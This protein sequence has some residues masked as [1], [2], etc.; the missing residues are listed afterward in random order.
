MF[1]S[2]TESKTLKLLLNDQWDVC[3]AFSF[4]SLFVSKIQKKVSPWFPQTSAANSC[5]ACTVNVMGYSTHLLSENTFKGTKHEKTAS[6]E[7][8]KITI[9]P[10]SLYLFSIIKENPHPSF[11]L[12]DEDVPWFEWFW[13]I[14]SSHFSL[15]VSSDWL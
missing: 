7:W 3:T 13:E 2:L 5:R 11:S 6:K 12:S 1:I 4:F 8:R 9:V 14:I 10:I 15:W